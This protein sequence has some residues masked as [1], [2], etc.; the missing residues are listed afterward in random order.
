MSSSALKHYLSPDEYLVG[1]SV[2]LLRHEYVAGQIYA[3]AGASERHNRITINL[4][5]QL[6]ARARGGSCG[7]FMSDMKLRIQQGEC[8]YYPDVMLVCDSLDNHAYFKEQPCLIAEVLSTSTEATDRREKWLAYQQIASL[9]Y[10]LVV[11]TDRRSVQYYQRNAKQQWELHS[12][13]THQ[14]LQVRCEFNGVAY[15][16]SLCMDDIYEDI[17]W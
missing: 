11:A 1:E 4:G 16:A 14:V 9:H 3:M 5:F 12:L 6:R 7:V 13:E 8:F 15:Q 10:Y 2:A 17:D